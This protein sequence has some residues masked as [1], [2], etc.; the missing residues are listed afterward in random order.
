VFGGVSGCRHRTKRARIGVDQLVGFQPSVRPNCGEAD[1]DGAGRDEDGS[2][3]FRGEAWRRG[4]MVRVVVRQQ[5]RLRPPSC[6]QFKEGSEVR[7]FIRSRVDHDGVLET[8]H[9]D[10]RP[11]ERHRRRVGREQGAQPVGLHGTRSTARTGDA[12]AASSRSGRAISSYSPGSTSSRR[13]FSRLTTPAA[14]STWCVSS[15]VES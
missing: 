15:A 12:Q 7:G 3:G 8:D 6:Q 11:V 1:V 5:D 10:A 4:G 9:E 2:A 13:R 14:R